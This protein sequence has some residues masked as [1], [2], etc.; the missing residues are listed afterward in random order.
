MFVIASSVR[1]QQRVLAH[2]RVVICCGRARRVLVEPERGGIGLL[3]GG[4]CNALPG[5][6]GTVAKLNSRCKR[7]VADLNLL[8]TSFDPATFQPFVLFLA[9]LSRSRRRNPFIAD[10]ENLGFDERPRP[11]QPV[12]CVPHNGAVHLNMALRAKGQHIARRQ[13]AQWEHLDETR[14]WLLRRQKA[15]VELR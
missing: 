10:L 9:R 6:D 1:S 4:R 3:V 8:S 15:I 14:L 11:L 5:R 2:V 13:I 7:R 12:V